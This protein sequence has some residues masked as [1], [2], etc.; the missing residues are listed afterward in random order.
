MAAEKSPGPGAASGK[1]VTTTPEAAV[2]EAK[3]RKT[4]RSGPL[5]KPARSPAP[6]RSCRPSD[7]DIP[8]APT[9]ANKDVEAPS[10]KTGA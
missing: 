8:K 6:P 1:K 7:E 9:K 3:S 10:R 5:L 4:R 2:Q